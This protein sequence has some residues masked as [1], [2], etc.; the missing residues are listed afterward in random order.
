MVRYNSADS[1]SGERNLP[2]ENVMW[3]VVTIVFY[4]KKKEGEIMP[5]PSVVRNQQHLPAILADKLTYFHMQ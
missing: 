2:G 3:Y 5:F 4:S 1:L